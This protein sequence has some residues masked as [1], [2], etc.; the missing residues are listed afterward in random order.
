MSEKEPVTYFDGGFSSLGADATAWSDARTALDEAEI[1]WLSTVRRDQRPHVTPLLG[2]WLDGSIYFCTGPDERKAKNLRLNSHCILTTGTNTLGG[3]DLVV[4]GDAGEVAEESERRSV[5][6]RFESKYG[7]H[8]AK[9]EGTWSGLGDA[10]RSGDALVY[11]VAPSRV[12]GFRKGGPYSQ[13][14]WD[15]V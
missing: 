11:R 4:E 10:M 5:A 12:F 2:V 1:F 6:D 13:T 3:L 15:F 9:P 8:F 14:R 7:A